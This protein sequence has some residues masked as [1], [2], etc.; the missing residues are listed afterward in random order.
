NAAAIDI[1]VLLQVIHRAAQAIGPG[2]NRSP[3]VCGGLGLIFLQEEWPHTMGKSAA[4]VGL[5]VLI[6]DSR[7][8][9]SAGEHLLNLKPWIASARFCFG[10]LWLMSVAAANCRE[11]DGRIVDDCLVAREVK[12]EDKRHGFLCA[13]RKI[14]EDVLLWTFLVR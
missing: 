11:F 12:A 13:R 8:A 2:S 14:D 3:I 5:N 1:F 9:V 4:E 7:E 10:L 6:I